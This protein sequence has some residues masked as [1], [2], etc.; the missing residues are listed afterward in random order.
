MFSQLFFIL[1]AL[2]LIN[3][4]PETGLSFWV[5][6]PHKAFLW[7]LLGYIIL[8]ILIYCQSKFLG[9]A[10]KKRWQSFEWP[11][12]NVELLLFLAL[13]HFGL[14][15]HRL[16]LQSPLASYQTPFTLVS[17]LFYFFALG[18]AHLWNA[19]FHLHHHLKKSFQT[20]CQQLLFYSPFCV[21]FVTISF[22]L[23]GL[24]HLPAWQ[25][26]SLPLSH[27]LIL[28]LFILSLLCLTLIFL[29][30]LM[31]VCWRCSPLHR[32]DLKERLEQICADLQFRHAGFKV[33]S[34]MSHSF[35]AGIIGIVPAF[36]YILFTPTLLNR[37][38]LEEV[39][40]ILI[41]EIGHNHHRHLLCYPFIM[42]GMLVSGT[43]LLIGLDHFLS[44]T[45]EFIYSEHGYFALIMS[46]FILY[47]LLMGLY[48]RIIFGFFSRLFERQADL[49]IFSSSL[50]PLFL[51][52]TLDHLGI[53][54]G[55]THSHPSW[56]HFSLQE[57][58]N[59]LH[60]AIENPA[61][62]ALHHR[63][64]KKWLIFYFFVLIVCSLALYS[65]I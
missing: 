38:K 1:L 63:R 17:L 3:F 28:F 36:R 55:Y 29:P 57:R 22:L 33:W 53:A 42:L 41:H 58:I 32:S 54:T 48:F 44:S 47:A 4:T 45:L 21:P 11:L 2:I 7:G 65:I 13:Y 25:S 61:I 46:I 30:A 49:F 23:D 10:L 8:L 64:V 51:I 16:F 19:H 37:F 62:I 56:H 5:N 26:E 50:S 27:D 20:A 31:V 39:E 60:Q 52:Q 9:P 14:G 43:L 59:F 15:A 6:E 18:W 35:T 40:A 24:E 34:V 12:I